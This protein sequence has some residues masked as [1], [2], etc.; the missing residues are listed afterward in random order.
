MKIKNLSIL[1]LEF[2]YRRGLAP[3]WDAGVKVTLIGTGG[4]DVKYQLIDSDKFDL[5]VG[6]GLAYMSI[7]SGDSKST[8]ID[9]TLPVYMSTPVSESVT[10]YASP[11]YFLRKA[12]GGDAL[13]ILA[14]TAGV[15][16]GE[17]SGIMLESSYGKAIGDDFQ[18]L[19]FNAAFFVKGDAWL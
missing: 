1:N 5:A 17:K 15:K 2:Q 18:S 8:L 14:M 12:T 10:L 6:A 13:N 16:M 3:K 4:A 7:E 19:Q 11:K 9:V